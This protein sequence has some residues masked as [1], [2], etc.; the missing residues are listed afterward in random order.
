MRKRDISDASDGERR[1]RDDGA[2]ARE[3]VVDRLDHP[4]DLEP[5]RSGRTWGAAA[6]DRVAEVG[7]LERQ[8][9][10]RLD[11]RRQ[12]VAGPVRELVFAER[13]GIRDRDTGVE[14]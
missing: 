1:D 4:N 14:D 13:L 11:A 2:A 5:E 3:R 8:R 10:R 12:V 7:Q 9:L 6:T